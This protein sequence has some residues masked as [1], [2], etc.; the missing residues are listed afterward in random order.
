MLAI[1]RRNAILEKL[2]EEKRVVVNELSQL[3]DVSE[4]TIR[5]DLEKLEQ[6]GLA[7][8]S[9]GGAVLN[10]NNNIDLPFNLRK[11]RNVGSKQKIGALMAKVIEDG[12]RLVLDAS[13]TAVFIAKAIKDKKNIT[14]ITNSVEILIELFDVPGWKV[15]S[16][17]GMAKEG[18]FALVG[19][20]T[21]RM[22]QLYHV[23]KA[24]VS[25]KGLD[26]ELGITDSD[27]QHAQN[28]Y[29]MLQTGE[30]R[31]LAV[32]HSKFGEVA[33]TRVD[34]LKG[35]TMV[36]TDTRPDEQW[37]KF[38]EQLGISCIYPE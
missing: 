9:Y 26:M 10:E 3:F 5:R 18:S 33:F 38:F 23:D 29:T 16:T 27:E 30:K 6:E 32:D 14:I 8:K 1:E 28:K 2:Q 17:G 15:I 11:N 19:P 36:V 12:D 25:C 34:G 21:D 22:L 24:I 35:V 4:E 20:Q 13:S 7:V 31:I 37:L